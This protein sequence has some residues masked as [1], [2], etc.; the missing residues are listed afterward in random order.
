MARLILILSQVAV[1]SA[2]ILARYGLAAGLTARDLTLWRLVLASAMLLPLVRVHGKPQGGAVLNGR[3]RLRLL[4]AGLAL[5]GHFW[6][7]FGSLQHVSVARSTLLASTTPVWAA[8]GAWIGTRSRPSRRFWIG[9]GLAILGAWLVTGGLSSQR[10]VVSGGNG[11]L[12]DALAILGAILIAAYFVLT[13]DLQSTIGTGRVITWTYTTA[14]V[15]ML[16]VA[17]TSTGRVV[18]PQGAAGWGAVLG[19]ALVPQLMGHTMLNWSLRHFTPEVVG[20]AT[21]LEPVFAG[22]LAWWLFGERLGVLQISGAA[23]LLLGLGIVL[24][25]GRMTVEEQPAG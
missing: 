2:A 10:T 12:G 21:L 3:V 24:S 9:T 11:P 15:V 7:W 25:V 23:T 20:A 5:A 4:I 1:G 19:M 18:M 6:A 22:A 14:A 17:L 8:A 13:S 16:G